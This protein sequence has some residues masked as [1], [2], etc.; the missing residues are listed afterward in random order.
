MKENLKEAIALL[1]ILAIL[2]GLPIW[3]NWYEKHRLEKKYPEARIISLTAKVNKDEC[4]WTEE[5]VTA[6]NYWWKKFKF[7]DLIKLKQGE[8]VVFRVKSADLLHSF[9][10]PRFRFGP[11]EIEA[12]KVKELI[13]KPERTGRFRYLCWLWCS[14]CHPDLKGKIQ[15]TSE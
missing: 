6:F 3:L 15:V 7:A 8:T 12:G 2:I 11:Y 13:F 1:T 5:S 10:I 14:E 4:I 9:A